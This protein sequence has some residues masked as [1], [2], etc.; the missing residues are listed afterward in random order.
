MNKVVIITG[1]SSGI[2]KKTARLFAQ[3]G[4]RVFAT[5]RNVDRMK[6]LAELGCITLAM[7]VT[8]EGNIQ[9]AFGQI[10]SQTDRVD[11]LVN[12]AGFSQNGFL[13]ELTLEH[14]HYQFE[15]NVFGLIRVTQAVLPLMRQARKGLIINIGSVGGDFTTAGSSAYHASKYAVESFTDGLR[16][17]VSQ[18]GIQVVL[19]K[20]GGVETEFVN[21]SVSFYPQPIEGNPYGPMRERFTKML[22][23]V[24]DAK[25]SSFPILSPLEVAEVIVQAASEPEPQTRY[26]IGQT[27]EVMPQLKASMSDREFDGMILKQLGFID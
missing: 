10:L 18:F 23:T 11:V 24:L 1:A 20:P 2:G 7:D 14:L 27:A 26:R 17:E 6:D 3:Q 5:A 19:I 4:Y 16:Q 12:N 13:E 21:N 8:S 15:V 25:N 9:Q 22:E